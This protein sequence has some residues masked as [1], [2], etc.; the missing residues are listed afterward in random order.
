MRPEA[1]EEALRHGS[2]HSGDIGY[3]DDDGSLHIV[4]RSKDMVIVNGFKVY[5]RHVEDAIYRHPAVAE[6]TVIGIPDEACGQV[7]K[8]FVAL[9]D[10][11]QLTAAEL[12]AFLA[13]KLSNTETPRRIEFRDEL[14]KTLIGKL[15]K[16]ELIE[17]ERQRREQ[18]AGEAAGEPAGEKVS[19]PA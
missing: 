9:R 5:P 1:T 6:V 3:R 18:A 12:Q 14:P 17:E 4:D 2:F 15:S 16:K 13:D 7:P 11:H 10:G 8:A 19:A